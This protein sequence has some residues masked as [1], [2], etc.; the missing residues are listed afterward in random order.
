MLEQRYIMKIKNYGIEEVQN[1]H[2]KSYQIL[3]NN[4]LYISRNNMTQPD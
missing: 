2:V 1:I 3:L 4:T